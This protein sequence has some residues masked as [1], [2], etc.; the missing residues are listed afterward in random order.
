MLDRTLEYANDLNI[1]MHERKFNGGKYYRCNRCVV[2]ERHSVCETIE[3]MIYQAEETREY[4]RGFLAGIYD[5]EGS[6]SKCNL[7]ICNNDEKVKDRIIRYLEVFGFQFTR[8]SKSVRIAGGQPEQIRF[9]SLVCPNV[10][11]KREALFGQRVYNSSAITSVYP[12][13]VRDV[14]NL[15]TTTENFVADGF[16]THNC[17][18][19]KVWGRKVTYNAVDRVVEEIKDIIDKFGVRQFRFYDDTITLNRRD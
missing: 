17:G 14:Y 13:G 5:A 6:F 16:I 9:L 10:R 1:H 7:R 19:R 3:K 18:S 4:V 11:H 8:E 2:C 12:V 15:S